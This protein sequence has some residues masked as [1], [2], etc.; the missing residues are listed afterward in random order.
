MTFRK[1]L[2]NVVGQ[3]YKIRPLEHGKVLFTPIRHPEDVVTTNGQTS[4]RQC[5]ATMQRSFGTLKDLQ[6]SLS[7]DGLILKDKLNCNQWNPYNERLYSG[8]VEE[9]Y[10][11]PEYCYTN[12]DEVREIV[13]KDM[14][15]IYDFITEEEEIWLF[16]EVEPHLKRL[17]YETSHWDDV[18]IISFKSS[19]FVLFVNDLQLF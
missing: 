4:K 7:S 1:C 10:P 8:A 16:K 18:C 3:C 14:K 6:K 5:N 19:P 13:C 15:V 9:K 2:Q 12:S 17:R 11:E